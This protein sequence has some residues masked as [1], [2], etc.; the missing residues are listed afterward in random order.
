MQHLGAAEPEGATT[1]MTGWNPQLTRLRQELARLALTPTNLQERAEEVLAV[2]G[3]VLPS[4]AAWLVPWPQ[5]L[6]VG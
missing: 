3:R 6:P 1:V 5:T 2:L 4:D